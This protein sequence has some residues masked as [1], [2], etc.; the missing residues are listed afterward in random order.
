M[1]DPDLDKPPLGNCP[2]CGAEGLITDPF[3]WCEHHVATYDLM[4]GSEPFDCLEQNGEFEAF[5][6]FLASFQELSDKQQQRLLESLP[7]GLAQ[8]LRD[9]AE[10]P[11]ELFWLEQ[12]PSKRLQADVSESLFDTTYVSIFVENVEAARGLLRGKVR[13]IMERL[14]PA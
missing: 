14:R 4:M 11:V 10:N 12:L 5:R 9:A 1:N 8:F 2:F 7:E 13:S 3:G 6:E